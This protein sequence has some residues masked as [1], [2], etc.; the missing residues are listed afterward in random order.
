LS[1]EAW[2]T[3]TAIAP[4]MKKAGIRQV[5]TCSRA[6]SWSIMKASSPD[7]RITGWLQGT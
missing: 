6:Y 4:A 7:W 2:E 3:K 5:R 1:T